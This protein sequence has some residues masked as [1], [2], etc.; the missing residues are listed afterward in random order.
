MRFDAPLGRFHDRHHR[1]EARDLG[2]Q[3]GVEVDGLAGSRGLGIFTKFLIWPLVMFVL[4]Y[5]D[6]NWTGLLNDALYKVM[7]VFAIVP[8]AANAVSMAVLLKAAPE[9]ASLA[10]L[11]S[12]L[13]SLFSIPVM[14]MLF[15]Y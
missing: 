11:L 1:R 4:V 15:L 7:F 3:I 6:K 10:V 9:K 13:F 8:L 12:T 2:A 14:C 5:V